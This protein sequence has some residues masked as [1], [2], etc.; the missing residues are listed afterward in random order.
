MSM[1]NSNDTIG[2][3]T[4]DLPACNTLEIY[5][6]PTVVVVM[7]KRRLFFKLVFVFKIALSVSSYVLKYYGVFQEFLL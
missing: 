3:R 6:L 1:K 7:P 5:G 2:N 4:R